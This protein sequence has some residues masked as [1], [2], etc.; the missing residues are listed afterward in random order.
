MT[1]YAAPVSLSGGKGGQPLPPVRAG[2][3]AA[4]Q[5]SIPFDDAAP[6]GRSLPGHGG[7]PK[8]LRLPQDSMPRFSLERALR[9]LNRIEDEAA[10]A[11]GD[12]SVLACLVDMAADEA[13]LSSIE[14]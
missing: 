5:Q 4:E 14:R 9:G 11:G 6:P 8:D 13:A 10:G 12:L 1:T 7:L 2:R 3:P